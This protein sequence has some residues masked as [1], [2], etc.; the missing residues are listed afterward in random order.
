[1]LK[2]LITKILIPQNQTVSHRIMLGIAHVSQILPTKS[3]L[4]T[5]HVPVMTLAKLTDFQL[6][7][8]QILK[9]QNQNF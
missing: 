2:V 5:I 3:N 1:M 9:I 4:S 8:L 7:K 6:L